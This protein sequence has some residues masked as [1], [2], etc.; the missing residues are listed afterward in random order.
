MAVKKTVQRTNYMDLVSKHLS[1]LIFQENQKIVTCCVILIITNCLDSKQL[2]KLKKFLNS[3]KRND[4]KTN[5]YVKLL[6]QLTM[7]EDRRVLGSKV[8]RKLSLEEQPQLKAQKQMLRN[9]LLTQQNK[10]WLLGISQHML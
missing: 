6:R 2:K 8:V 1:F 7:A 10:P 9:I 4:R 5:F 3:L